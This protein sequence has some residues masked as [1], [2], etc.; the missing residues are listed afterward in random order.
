[1][2]RILQAKVKTHQDLPGLDLVESQP[3]DEGM[4]DLEL[5]I[6]SNADH[7]AM[8]EDSS[9]TDLFLFVV[10]FAATDEFVVDIGARSG[11]AVS[12]V[13]HGVVLLVK[14]DSVEFKLQA[15]DKWVVDDNFTTTS[16][17]KVPRQD[18]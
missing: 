8:A 10:V 17:P 15:R 16:K 9:R 5:H 12:D 3:R 6:L 14:D 1:M 11:I 7:V 18:N 4:D 2:R 13:D